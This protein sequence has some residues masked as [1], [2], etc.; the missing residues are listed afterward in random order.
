MPIRGTDHGLRACWQLAKAVHFLWK[1]LFR[2]ERE[3]QAARAGRGKRAV[4]CD[5]RSRGGAGQGQRGARDRQHR[6]GRAADE[7]GRAPG[8]RGAG[9]RARGGRGARR[10]V[11]Q[12]QQA[13]TARKPTVCRERL[14]AFARPASRPSGVAPFLDMLDFCAY[15]G[16]ARAGAGDAPRRS[17]DDGGLPLG[18]AALQAHSME[19]DPTLKG[20]DLETPSTWEKS[21]PDPLHAGQHIWCK[22]THKSANELVAEVAASFRGTTEQWT[23]R[24]GDCPPAGRRGQRVCAIRPV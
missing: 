2:A 20:Y 23:E 24:C 13:E 4:G 8:H 19:V 17:G 22:A 11:Q 15:A 18:R 12:A 1:R 3:D 14:D 6:Q 5:G 16:T 21:M 9:R 7:L 10:A